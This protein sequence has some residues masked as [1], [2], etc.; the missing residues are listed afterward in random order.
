MRNSVLIEITHLTTEHQMM[1]E[2][3]RVL[4][5]AIDEVVIAGLTD[6]D[7]RRFRGKVHYWKNR[8]HREIKTRW[9]NERQ[10]FRVFATDTI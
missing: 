9:D 6:R 10:E 3:S 8:G 7:M 4:G 1:W 5:G 2:V